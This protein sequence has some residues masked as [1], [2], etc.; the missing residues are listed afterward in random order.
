VEDA[1]VDFVSSNDDLEIATFVAQTVILHSSTATVSVAS[2]SENST[3]EEFGTDGDA[4]VDQPSTQVTQFDYDNDVTTIEPV[5]LVTSTTPPSSRLQEDLVDEA[6]KISVIGNIIEDDISAF[7]PTG[8]VTSNLESEESN[9]FEKDENIVEDDVSAFL[10]PGFVA[11]YEENYIEST[12]AERKGSYENSRSGLLSNGFSPPNDENIVEDDI[13]SLPLGFAPNSR[14]S[15]L[16]NRY[17][18]LRKKTSKSIDNVKKDVE[19]KPETD[20]SRFGRVT[21]TTVDPISEILANVVILDVANYLPK[22]YDFSQVET[23]EEEVN[24]DV[25]NINDLL[26]KKEE[27]NNRKFKPGKLNG[28]KLAAISKELKEADRYYSS[29]GEEKLVGNNEKVLDVQDKPKSRSEPKKKISLK[30][31]DQNNENERNG[32]KISDATFEFSAE[33]IF[34]SILG[35][36]EIKIDNVGKEM[37]DDEKPESRPKKTYGWREPKED[38]ESFASVSPSTSFI[39]PR[40]TTTPIPTTSTPRPTTPGV[41]GDFCNLAGT[42]FIKSGLEWSE[43]LSYP[44]TEEYKDATKNIVREM[45]TVFDQVY[46]GSAFEFASV[47]AFSTRDEM[48][49][50]DIYVQFSD[51]V[52]NITTKDV[53]E[54]FE[55]LLTVNGSKQMMGMFEIDMVWTYFMVVDTTIPLASMTTELQGVYLPDW[56]LLVA[57]VGVIS[58]FI[59]AFLGVVMGFNKY[60][61]NQVL[62]TRVLNPKTL[63]QFRGQRHFDKV[64]V[65]HVTAYAQDKR[66]MW[67]LQKVNQ[68]KRRSKTSLGKKF[69]YADSGRGSSSTRGSEK[70]LPN[71]FGKH[72]GNSGKGTFYERFPSLGKGSSSG[73]NPNDS[74]AELLEGFDNSGFNSSGEILDRDV[75]DRDT[76]YE[77]ED[78]DYEDEVRLSARGNAEYRRSD[79]VNAEQRNISRAN[80]LHSLGEQGMTF[81][82]SDSSLDAVSDGP[83]ERL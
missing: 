34:A 46:F 57:V 23:E 63:Q 59:V 38:L 73:N 69:G 54:S 51:I 26:I 4:E 74:N 58:T 48:V 19:E 14:V 67:T 42:I 79:N 15:S 83:S 35:G 56:A 3:R 16:K 18:S 5:H 80:L 44:S 61:H 2:F 7:L 64:E 17:K 25:E 8:F 6:S 81:G 50:V 71:Q 13:A 43:E 75:A 1:T 36:E 45:T 37:R 9:T 70:Y 52:F 55:E 27:E 39:P 77:N 22:G 21:T 41:C 29:V 47:E 10:P 53:K 60:R 78:D 33:S 76:S 72:F 62:K 30:S 20:L 24:E 40:T 66:D 12:T 32:K 31:K 49:L 28:K 82:D 68:E 11:K 65:D